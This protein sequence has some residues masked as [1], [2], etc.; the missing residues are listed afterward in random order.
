MPCLLSNRHAS[1]LAGNDA[2]MMVLYN[3]VVWRNRLA[4]GSNE[5]GALGFAVTAIGAVNP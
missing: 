1:V 4:A 2:H 3:R 5:S